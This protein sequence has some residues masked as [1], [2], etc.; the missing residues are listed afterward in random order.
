MS[1]TKITAAEFQRIFFEDFDK[2]E[3]LLSKTTMNYVDPHGETETSAEGALAHM[4]KMRGK[5]GMGGMP[6]PKFAVESD[7]CCSAKFSKLVM[8]ITLQDTIELDEEGL[9]V[10]IIRKKL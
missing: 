1:E 8:K 4:K 5:L 7:A 2:M 6:K 10:S 9:I 3:A